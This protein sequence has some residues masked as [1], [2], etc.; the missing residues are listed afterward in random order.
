MNTIWKFLL[1]AGSPIRM[2]KGAD[3]L[4]VAS[5]FGQD[6]SIWA[7]VN[8]EA[9]FEDRMF[10][11]APTGGDLPLDQQFLGTAILH[12]GNIIMHVFEEK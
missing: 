9:E 7:S 3:V 6:I 8:P 12:N 4:H 11:V 5:Q 2:P 10:T 1:N